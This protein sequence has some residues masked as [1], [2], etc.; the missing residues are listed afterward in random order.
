[1]SMT[2]TYH[3]N[4]DQQE[5]TIEQQSPFKRLRLIKAQ[6]NRPVSSHP[7]AGLN[8]N[9]QNNRYSY[10]LYSFPSP[11]D[12]RLFASTNLLEQAAR[13]PHLLKEGVFKLIIRPE[14]FILDQQTEVVIEMEIL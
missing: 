11:S 1:M 10:H 8:L 3:L 2:Q 7:L 13:L 9:L 5:I 12:S 6:S 14:L 4:A